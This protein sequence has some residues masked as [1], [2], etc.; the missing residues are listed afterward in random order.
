MLFAGNLIKQPPFRMCV[1]GARRP[2][3][4]RQGH[5]RQLLDR[6]LAGIDEP[7]LDYM[8]DTLLALTRELSGARVAA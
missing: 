7:R 5:E 6:R 4:H 8:A 3:Q 1:P 2:H